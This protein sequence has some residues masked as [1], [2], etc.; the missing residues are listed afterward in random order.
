MSDPIYLRDKTKVLL[1]N[2]AVKSALKNMRNSIFNQ[3]ESCPIR[4]KEGQHELK[5]MLKMLNDFEKNLEN[6][7]AEGDAAELEIT[8]PK[9]KWL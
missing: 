6:F 2:E 1:D 7:V 5:L 9:R 3:W 4:D 8:Q